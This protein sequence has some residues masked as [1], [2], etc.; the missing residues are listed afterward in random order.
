MLGGFKCNI[1]KLLG[2]WAHGVVVLFAHVCVAASNDAAMM[3]NKLKMEAKLEPESIK[4][5][6]KRD[7]EINAKKEAHARTSLEG[8]RVWRAF[9][10][11]K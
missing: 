10:M 1:Y 3:E 8:Q 7:P 9:I 11:T 6:R 2:S 5:E 4:C